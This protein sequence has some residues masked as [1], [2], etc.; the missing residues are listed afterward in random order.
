MEFDA[1]LAAS[2]MFA[3]ETSWDHVHPNLD[4]EIRERVMLWLLLYLILGIS[5]PFFPFL[6]EKR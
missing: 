6:D 3:Y 4:L 5:S 2:M 1:A